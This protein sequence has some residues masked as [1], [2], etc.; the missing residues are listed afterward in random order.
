M[1]SHPVS[2][3]DSL[4]ILNKE[5]F[6]KNKLI[7]LI[8]VTF[9]SIAIK[10]KVIFSPFFK[11]KNVSSSNCTYGLSITTTSIVKMKYSL[12][13]P[14]IWISYRSCFSVG[15]LNTRLKSKLSF[16]LSTYNS[17]P[18]RTVSFFFVIPTICTVRPDPFENYSKAASWAKN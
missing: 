9:F 14:W 1:N 16:S 12:F 17:K 5:L 4:S 7:F 2:G 8:F 6:D 18:P 11:S 10:W 15:F 3:H 13:I